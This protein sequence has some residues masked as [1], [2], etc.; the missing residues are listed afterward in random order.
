[1][2]KNFVKTL[3]YAANA[4][5]LMNIN[6]KKILKV[7]NTIKIKIKSFNNENIIKFGGGII[8]TWWNYISRKIK[9]E[10]DKFERKC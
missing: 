7:K 2:K 5:S 6:S 10:T 9:I 1:M 8:L 4:V 3:K